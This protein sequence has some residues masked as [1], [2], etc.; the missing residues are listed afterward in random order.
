MLK[1]KKNITLTGSSV[2]DGKVAEGYSAII[3]STNPQD[4]NIS[5]W[6]QDK[7]LYKE[8]RAQCRAD[9]AEFEDLAYVCQDE[10][11][12]AMEAEKEGLLKQ[13]ERTEK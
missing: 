12:A 5:S 2:I 13:A 4:I 8:N 10:M 1:T 6:Q 9:K 11:I 3:D 7:G